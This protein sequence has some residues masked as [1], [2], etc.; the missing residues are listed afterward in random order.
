MKIL[1]TTIARLSESDR[2][3]DRQT[4]RASERASEEETEIE[5]DRD[6]Y[7]HIQTLEIAATS[8]PSVSADAG[9]RQLSTRA[10]ST[11]P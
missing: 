11:S 2:Q 4:D 10:V 9:Q 7:T 3:T 5:R 1:Y 6:A 8:L